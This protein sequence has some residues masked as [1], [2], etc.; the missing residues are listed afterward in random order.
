M[1]NYNQN[2]VGEFANRWGLSPSPQLINRITDFLGGR[3]YLTALLFFHVCDGMPYDQILNSKT[4]GNGIYREHLNRYLLRFQQDPPLARAMLSIIKGARCN[5]IDL[6]RRL[7]AAGL[8]RLNADNEPL[9]ASELYRDFYRSEL[10][11]LL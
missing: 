2:E 11:R 6:I 10:E 3:P 9:P 1:Y 4:A 5:N 8:I 7:E